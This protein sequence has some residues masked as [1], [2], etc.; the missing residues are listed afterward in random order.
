MDSKKVKECCH[1]I[2]SPLEHA[3]KLEQLRWLQ[4]G[5]NIKVGITTT[6]SYGVDTMDDLIKVR[7][8]YKSK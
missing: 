1:A 6:P 8:L 3:E 7:E 2:H 4:A 5:L